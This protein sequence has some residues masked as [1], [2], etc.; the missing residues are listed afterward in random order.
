MNYTGG[1]KNPASGLLPHVSPWTT[2]DVR[3]AY[4][5]RQGAGWLGGA[6]F[7]VNVT[8]VLNHEPPFV[9]SIYGYDANNVQPLGRVV[10]ADITKSW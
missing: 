7:S 1:Y 3:F 5:T 10:S 8:N 2:L 4:R 6:E 9:D